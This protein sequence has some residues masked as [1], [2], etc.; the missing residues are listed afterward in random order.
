M[1]VKTKFGELQG[2]SENGCT[3][4]KGIPYAKPPVGE[5]RWKAPQELDSRQGVQN[6]DKFPNRC[7]QG[8]A[9]PEEF[10]GKEFY[11]KPA[12]VPPMSED[13]LYLN[14]WTPENPGNEK[15]PVAFWIHGGAFLHGFGSELEF[16][17]AEYC[18]RGVI[19]VTINYRVN[20]FGFLAH[21][22]LADEN[23]LSGNYGILDQIAAL[24]WVRENITAFGGDAD[25]ITVFGQSA[26]AMSVQTL[27]SSELT[28]GMISAAIF[29]SAGGYDSPLNKDCSLAEAL[30]T[31]ERFV[32][33]TGAKSA[34]ALRAMS[35]EE[36]FAAVGKFLAESP[37]LPF[38]PIVDGLLMKQG[39]TE[40]VDKNLH[41]DIPYM[42]GLTMDDIGSSEGTAGTDNPLY[43]ACVGWSLKNESLGRALSYVYYFKHRPLGDDAGAFHSCEL[44]YM[45]G[46]LD[47]SWRPKDAADYALSEKMLGYWTNFM[48]THNPNGSGLPDWQPCKEENRFIMELS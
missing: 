34:E 44:W 14:I 39:Y 3:V 7:V 2:V 36:I 13:C 9:K 48:K 41:H 37:M 16:D 45:F 42:L 1:T 26:G 31:G 20:A 21:R 35:A 6:A 15:L 23:G 47:R 10:Y 27:C 8:I 29:Q 19:L 38:R 24:K 40:T 46:T 5:L 11:S 30:E 18:K 28:K 32:E 22:W 12:F 17:G 4:Y 33:I 25:N 43:K